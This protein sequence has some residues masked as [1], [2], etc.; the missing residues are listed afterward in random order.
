MDKCTSCT[1]AGPDVGNCGH[2][3]TCPHRSVP[4][5]PKKD[6]LIHCERCNMTRAVPVGTVVAHKPADLEVTCQAG[7]ELCEAFVVH[8]TVRLNVPKA[9]SAPAKPSP[10]KPPVSPPDQ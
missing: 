7:R 3:I 10:A 9:A 6:I 8:Q 2:T 1:R 4:V 5:D